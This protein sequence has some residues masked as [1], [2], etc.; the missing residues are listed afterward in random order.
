MLHASTERQGVADGTVQ[1]TGRHDGEDGAMT[2]PVSETEETIARAAEEGRNWGRWGADDQIGTLNHIDSAKIVAAAR[3]VQR[4][5]V[6]SL[7]IPFDQGGPQSGRNNR[8]NPVHTMT[9]TGTDAVAGAQSFLPHGLGVADDMIT[10]PLQ[11]GTQW[12]GL[13]HIFDHGKM[14]NGYSAAEVSSLGAKRNGIEQASNRFVSRG[15]LLDIARNKA[16]D[17]LDPGYAITSDDLTEC[18]AA[19]GKTAT[20]G[21]GD[22]VL[23]RT[24]QLGQA[25]QDR[26][27]GYDGGHAPGLSFQT[28]GWLHA[29][30]IAAVAI[31]TWGLEV[32]PNELEGSFQPLHQ[33]LIPNVGL[34]LGEIFDLDALATDC[35]SDGVYEFLFVAPPL[36]ITGAVGSPVNPYAIK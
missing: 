30:E 4:G 15:V 3:L 33:V 12:D 35:A 24:G 25:R 31:D 26:W 21:R 29:N 27:K 6:F 34:T 28:A 23:I 36:P 5:V 22:V 11:C 14:W 32:R 20:V 13:A 10:M 7:A 9:I 2:Q 16:S 19:Q 18:I 17:A 1:S 8:F